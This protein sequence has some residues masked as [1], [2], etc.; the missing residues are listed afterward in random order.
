VFYS[1]SDSLAG[2]TGA[3]LLFK[4]NVCTVFGMVSLPA[5]RLPVARPPPARPSANAHPKVEL[6][7][8]YHDV[9]PSFGLLPANCSI[10]TITFVFHPVKL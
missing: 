1:R 9:L 3:G 6:E 8:V 5:R 10:T 2:Q 7:Y 4:L